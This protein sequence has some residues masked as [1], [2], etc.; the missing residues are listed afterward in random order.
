MKS[1]KP[2]LFILFALAAVSQVF[3][4]GKKEE[5]V[6]TFNDK[7]ILCVTDFDISSVPE[8]K[9]VVAGVITRKI[10]ERLGVID[11]RIR[12]S[13]EYAY[14]ESQVWASQRSAAAKALAAKQ[15]DR[16]Q[17]V[18]K[19]DAKWKYKQNLAKI[20][21]DIEKLRLNL[22]ELDNNAPLINSEPEFD[23]TS[24]NK[25][26]TFPAAPK[27][28]LEVKFCSD[29]KADAFV[30]GS[31]VDFYGR[32]FISLN[33]YT[34]YT[35][36]F[37]YEDNI[38]FSTDDLES[39][40]DEITEKLIFALSGGKPSAIVVK[41]E[42]KDALVLINRSFAGRGDTGIIERPPGKLI[43][44]ASAPDHES[45]TVETD[46]LPGELAEIEITL[47]PFEYGSVEIDPS[48]SGKVYQGA[49]FAGEPPLTLR[50]P[51]N[52]L[53]YVELE[54]HDKQK[55][56]AV[57][58][59]PDNVNSEYMI[60]FKTEKPLEKGRVDKARRQ[61]YWAWGGTWITGIAAWLTTRNYMDA[62]AVLKSYYDPNNYNE[63][64]QKFADNNARMY[65]ISM[66]C[67]IAVSAAVAYEV[68][69][70][71]RYIYISNKGTTPIVKTNR[72]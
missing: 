15:N 71:G 48:L 13:G 5:T 24:G 11:Y 46:L 29:Q 61:Y 72:K 54:T 19:G 28:G 62:D 41:A 34:L 12:I 57:F 30:T 17:Y 67:I 4:L 23:L 66:G 53:E 25:N 58:Y 32:F 7:W 1:L 47:A 9:K 33:L 64:V 49:L 8:E 18:F 51:L 39:A 59:T 27:A 22:E 56:T 21:I 26:S 50:L 63:N 60:T 36:S 70:I 69:Q 3:A 16:S 20:D 35:R 40:L 10:V 68:F 52:I 31:I 45:M 44:D 42:P 55:G 65:Y 14:Y 43:I 38:I 37:V 6:T 2:A